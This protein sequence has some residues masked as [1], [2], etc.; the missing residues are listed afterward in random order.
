MYSLIAF[1]MRNVAKYINHANYYCIT[2]S[3]IL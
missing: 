2:Y 3:I 1:A